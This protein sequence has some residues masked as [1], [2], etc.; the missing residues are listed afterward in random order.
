MV[1]VV[2]TR[3]LLDVTTFLKA[4]ASSILRSSLGTGRGG[5]EKGGQIRDSMG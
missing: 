2:S 1:E 5:L 3:A 4:A